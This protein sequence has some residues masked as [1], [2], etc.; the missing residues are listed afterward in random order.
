MY[1]FI[2][3]PFRDP[4]R[5]KF[6]SRAGLGL[7]CTAAMLI[8]LIPSAI[9]WA[10]GGL[11]WRGSVLEVS[12]AELQRLE[13]VRKQNEVD[14]FLRDRPFAPDRRIKL[15]FVGD[16]HSGDIAAAMFLTLG[17][18]KYDYARSRFAPNCFSSIDRRPWILRMTHTKSLCESD[19]DALRRNRSL[20]QAD[21]LFVADRWSEEYIKGF[22]D[23]L[24]LLRDLTKARIIIV[25]QN[26]VFPTF[27]DSL[28]FLD[29]SQLARLN[30]VMYDA[31][32]PEDVLHQRAATDPGGDQ[33]VGFHRSAISGVLAGVQAVPGFRAGRRVPLHGYE[34]LEL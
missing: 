23:G 20:A 1:T 26:A 16:S 2:E 21:Y 19:L 18:E 34:S 4:R 22:P 10:K 9:V 33:R 31:K 3:Q 6:S 15:M 14:D 11:L 8:L 32:S 12:A 17:D 30:R 7:A 27:D 28:R 24:A 5:V 13:Q 29:Q 25:G